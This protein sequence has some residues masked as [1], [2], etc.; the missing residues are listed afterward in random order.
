MM[1]AA[2]HIIL[3]ALLILLPVALVV[4]LVCYYWRTH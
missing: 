2:F 4:L 3:F 1:V